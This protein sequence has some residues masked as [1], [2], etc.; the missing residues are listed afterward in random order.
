[1]N[2]Q[3]LAIEAAGWIGAVL[4]LAAY[5][6]ASAGRLDGKSPIF[7]W[8]NLVGAVG[9]VVNTAYHGAIPSMVLN[10]IWCG[11]AMLTLVRNRA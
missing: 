10:I 9:F 4:V 5:A 2:G 7:Q 6:L 3:T 8:L 11:I 1:M